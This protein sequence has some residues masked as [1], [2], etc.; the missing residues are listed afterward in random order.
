VLYPEDG[1]SIKSLMDKADS[2]MYQVKRD[3][4][5]DLRFNSVSMDINIAD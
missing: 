3:G 2:T 1:D 4:K 5:G